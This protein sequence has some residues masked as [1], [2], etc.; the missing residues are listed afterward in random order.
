[1]E[2]SKSDYVKLKEE[3]AQ[4]VGVV[5]EI[6]PTEIESIRVYWWAGGNRWSKFYEPKNL[7]LVKP[8]ELPDYAIELRGSLGL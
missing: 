5:W 2:F 1:M 7:T 3:A 6:D 4:E 8:T